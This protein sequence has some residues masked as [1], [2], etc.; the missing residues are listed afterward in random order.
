MARPKR[1]VSPEALEVSSRID[2]MTWTSRTQKMI[3]KRKLGMTLEAIGEQHG[4]SRERVRQ[5]L[6]E[7][8]FCQEKVVRSDNL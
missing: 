1:L 4:L 2:K 7:A 3:A 8:G 5:I 6:H